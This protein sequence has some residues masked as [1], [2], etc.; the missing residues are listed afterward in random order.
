VFD[1][2]NRPLQALLCAVALAAC[3]TDTSIYEASRG[4]FPAD[5]KQRVKVAIESTW[6]AP[7]D[8]RVLAI[9]TPNGGY[10]LRK[11]TFHAVFGAWIGCVQLE[12]DKKR[13]AKFNSLYA[14]YAIG[15]GG[16]EFVLRDEIQC[17]H[18][19]FEAW[20]D[21]LEGSET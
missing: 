12:G 9:S 2:K 8:F 19:S 15:T 10:L 6:P 14:P 21:M 18:A 5:Y 17:H 4:A 20:L 11:G 13:G 3:T 7:R 16:T 1:K